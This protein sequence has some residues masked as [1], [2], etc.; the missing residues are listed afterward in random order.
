MIIDFRNFLFFDFLVVFT[1]RMAHEI[2]VI[3]VFQDPWLIVID[4]AWFLNGVH[5]LIFVRY[6]LDEVTST[7][8]PSA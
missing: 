1:H 5:C 3:S 8:G 2:G 6:I 7:K 4:T